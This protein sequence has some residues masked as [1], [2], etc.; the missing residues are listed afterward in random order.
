MM[1]PYGDRSMD[2]RLVEVFGN[3]VFRFES[4]IH[5]T[6]FENFRTQLDEIL[7]LLRVWATDIRADQS[8]DPNCLDLLESEYEEEAVAVRI[9]MH[10]ISESLEALEQQAATAKDNIEIRLQ[11]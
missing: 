1:K 7:L 5:S 3:L 6:A 4:I 9:H 8:S 11:R 2:Q 10:M